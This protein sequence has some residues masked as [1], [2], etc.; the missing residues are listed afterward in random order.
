MGITLELL[1]MLTV[2]PD[3][4]PDLLS[5]NLDFSKISIDDS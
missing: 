3:P 5:P 4:T 1:E 2:R